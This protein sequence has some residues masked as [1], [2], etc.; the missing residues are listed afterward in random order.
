MALIC[1][2][3]CSTYIS[4]NV[5]ILMLSLTSQS[6]GD[7]LLAVCLPGQVGVIYRPPEHWWMPDRPMNEASV[8]AD[9]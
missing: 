8:K 2:V 4:Q 5:A 3:Y 1:A 9:H 7:P 6:C